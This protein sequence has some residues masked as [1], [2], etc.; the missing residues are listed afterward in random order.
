MH[1]IA[2]KIPY[3]IIVKFNLRSTFRLQMSP[4]VKNAV[5]P[6]F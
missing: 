2:I 3:R 6:I 5:Q 4:K 1:R